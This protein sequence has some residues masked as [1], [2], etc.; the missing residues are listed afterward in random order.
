MEFVI[1]VGLSLLEGN[2]DEIYEN[3]LKSLDVTFLTKI[4][5]AQNK[6]L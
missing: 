3:M 1:S 4:L 6:K 5:V 2:D